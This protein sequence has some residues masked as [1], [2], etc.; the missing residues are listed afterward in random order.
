[1][2]IKLVIRNIRFII[3]F[4]MKHQNTVGKNGKEQG[5]L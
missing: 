1:M 4:E 2:M 5:L 3:S